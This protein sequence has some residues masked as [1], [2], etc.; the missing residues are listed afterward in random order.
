LFNADGSFG[1]TAPDGA[2]AAGTYRVTADQFCLTLAGAEEICVAA[3][4]ADKNIGDSWE[5]AGAD[6]AAMTIAIVSGR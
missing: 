2:Q 5:T 1:M 4:P 6:G 3:P